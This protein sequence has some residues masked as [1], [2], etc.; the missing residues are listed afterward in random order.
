MGNTTLN[1]RIEEFVKEVDLKPELKID[2]QII[3]LTGNELA[4]VLLKVSKNIRRGFSID[5]LLENV[6]CILGE[7]GISERVLLFQI[8]GG[9]TKALLTQY[10]ESPYVLK[11]NPIGFQL[12]IKDTPLFKL[13]HLNENRTLQIEDISRYLSLPN[14]LLR[15]KFKAL[16]I[17]LKTK[18]L[19][20]ATGSINKIRV[21][22]NLQYCTRNVIWSNEIEKLLQSIVD[23]LAVAIE[24]SSEKRKKEGLQKDLLKLQESTTKEQEELFKR[25]ARDVHDLPCSIIPN[26]K[27]A[28][29]EKNFTD[30]EKLVD[31]LHHTLR[32]IINEYVLPD[33]NLLGFTSTIYQFIN[34]FRKTFNGKICLGLPND[35][36]HISQIKAIEIY[37]VIKEWF[38]NIDKHSGATE[39]FFNLQRLNEYYFLISISDNGKGFDTSNTKNLGYGLLNIKRRLLE[40]NARFQIESK[41][42]KGSTLKIQFSSE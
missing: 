3:S 7:A 16:F 23:Q 28:V 40:I 33:I 32:Q 12:D 22:L 31:E 39:V 26:L 11:F 6:A 20:V 30:C 25:F 24:Q 42:G 35:E 14:Y 1:G 29:K 18:S 8:N 41:L 27:R 34:G 5:S 21:S 36:I 13:F 19:L 2:S 17:K 10:F 15:N 38:C 37:K 4:E 9:G